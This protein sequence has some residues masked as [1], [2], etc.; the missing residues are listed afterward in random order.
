M[1]AICRG[2]KSGFDCEKINDGERKIAKKM[3]S[4]AK[5]VNFVFINKFMFGFLT[6]GKEVLFRVSKVNVPLLNKE[7]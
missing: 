4:I 1:D 3:V 6:E 5:A 7:G 2:S